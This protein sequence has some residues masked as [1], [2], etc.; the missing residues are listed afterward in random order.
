MRAV[1]PRVGMPEVT[2]AAN[3]DEYL[4]LTGAVVTYEDGSVGVVTR[5]RLSEVEKFAIARGE[6]L[7]LTLLT[8]GGPMQPVCL[9]VGPPSWAI[10]REPPT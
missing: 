2:I 10:E 5:W 3:Q 7:Y 8:G 9:E 4:E 6:D 1:A